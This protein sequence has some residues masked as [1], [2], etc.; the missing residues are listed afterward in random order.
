MQKNHQFSKDPQITQCAQR[1]AFCAIRYAPCALR[2][3]QQYEMAKIEEAKKGITF[4][5]IDRAIP[6]E[7]KIKPKR[8]RNVMFAGVVSLF[9]GI[10]LVFFLEYLENLK[11]P[12]ESD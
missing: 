6:P 1:Y 4:Q 8:R 12:E 5:V 3:P 11:K 7:K 10:F 9:A 2:H